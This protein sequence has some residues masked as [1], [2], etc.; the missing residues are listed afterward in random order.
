MGLPTEIVVV[1]PSLA[2]DGSV[3]AS[4]GLIQD[5]V[6]GSAASIVVPPG[7]VTEDTVVA[8]DVFESPLDVPTP[9]G[10]L[11][12]GTHFGN[13][14]LEPE[15][16]FPFPSPGATLV[17]PLP[18]PLPPGLA[19]PLFFVDE[20]DGSL[21]PMLDLSGTPVVGTVDGGGQTATFMGISHF[22]IVVG[23]VSGVT[24]A[25]IDI[26][27]GSFPNSINLKLPR[28]KARDSTVD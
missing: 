9:N 28:L 21:Q 8:I 7:A 2:P 11:G 1:R 19:M 27:P 23:L 5:D 4:G 3:D 16:T 15:P 22:S 26:K 17:L 13:I 20:S 6:F 24:Q 18:V 12:P 14:N 10:F 25:T